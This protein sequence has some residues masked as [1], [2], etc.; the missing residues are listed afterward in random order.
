MSFAL[1]LE[2]ILLSEEEVFPLQGAAV[3]FNR[4]GCPVAAD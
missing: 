4:N 3:F 2:N 1:K